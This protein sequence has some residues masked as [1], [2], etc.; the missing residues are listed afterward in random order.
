MRYVL[1]LRD[2]GKIWGGH[3]Y[4]LVLGDPPHNFVH[5]FGKVIILF[6]NVCNKKW[7]FSVMI[8]I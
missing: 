6:P 1:T 2:I 5:L 4:V 3:L 7:Y 8:K